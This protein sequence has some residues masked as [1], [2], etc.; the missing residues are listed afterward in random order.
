MSDQASFL[1]LHATETPVDESPLKV[2]M[3]NVEFVAAVKTSL[4][5]GLRMNRDLYAGS[6]LPGNV[7]AL[8]RYSVTLRQ[9]ER[10]LVPQGFGITNAKGQVHFTAPESFLANSNLR[11]AY[12]SGAMLKPEDAHYVSDETIHVNRKGS[13]TRFIIERQEETCPQGSLFDDPDAPPKIERAMFVIVN[14][15]S[16]GLNGLPEAWIAYPADLNSD[17]TEITCQDIALLDLSDIGTDLR[18][19]ISTPEAV[20]VKPELGDSDSQGV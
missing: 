3:A 13:S 12:F 7:Q 18:A 15:K 20:L 4:V 11:F 5:D 16:A 1:T 17:G 9:F 19:P 8:D 10:G 14:Y 6:E 2:V